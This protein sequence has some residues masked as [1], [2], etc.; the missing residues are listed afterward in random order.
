V[1]II[2]QQD[3]LV[4]AVASTTSLEEVDALLSPATNFD[5][6]CLPLAETAE[7]LGPTI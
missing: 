1:R 7:S 3:E 2:D 4:A 5:D 6:A